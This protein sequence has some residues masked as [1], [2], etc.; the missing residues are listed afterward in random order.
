MDAVKNFGINI[1]SSPTSMV[2]V[3]LIFV[4]LA[5]L[6][7]YLRSCASWLPN[8]GLLIYALL[9]A[10]L[11]IALIYSLLTPSVWWYKLIILLFLVLLLAFD[12]MSIKN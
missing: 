3:A 5:I 7:Y 8:T 11:Y 10:A 2:I 1:K 12:W 4:G 9:G 6:L